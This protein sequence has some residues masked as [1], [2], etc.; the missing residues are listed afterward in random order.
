MKN[1]EIREK[2]RQISKDN[3]ALVDSFPDL[4][5]IR[6]KRILLAHNHESQSCRHD[7]VNA[8]T[9]YLALIYGQW[10]LGSFSLQWYGWS[11]N[12]W[13]GAGIQLNGIQIL[14]ATD[15]KKPDIKLTPYL[16]PN[17]VDEYGHEYED[18][19]EERYYDDET[20]FKC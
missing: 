7:Q 4:D 12:N 14:Y 20:Y 10:C 15:L 5:G 17:H 18:G 8:D 13:G 11:F 3:D 2:N 16:H 1:D 9:I 6:L 19:E